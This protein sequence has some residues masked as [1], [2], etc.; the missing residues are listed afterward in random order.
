MPSCSVKY[1]SW[2]PRSTLHHDQGQGLPCM[3]APASS[4]PHGERAEQ[5]GRA[6]VSPGS[7]QKAPL[8]LIHGVG[9]SLL[10][11]HAGLEANTLAHWE[12][13]SLSVS[14][15]GMH[16]WS[17]ERWACPSGDVCGL[18]P[19]V[20]LFCPGRHQQQLGVSQLRD[21]VWRESGWCS[22]YIHRVHGGLTKQLPEWEEERV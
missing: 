22:P 11:S 21:G 3:P 9:S 10:V 4:H 19:R 6:Q 18:R 15:A 1:I 20:P 8:S 17:T 14:S 12:C 13:S 16:L 2:A 7:S 5:G